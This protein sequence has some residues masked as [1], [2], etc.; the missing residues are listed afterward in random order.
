[1]NQA[2][3]LHGHAKYCWML[4]LRRL[5]TESKRQ[6]KLEG[7][8]VSV[9]ALPP[10]GPGVWQAQY[11]RLIAFPTVP[12]FGHS[13]NWWRDLTGVEPQSNIDRPQRQEQEVSGNY[14]GVE[15]SLAVVLLRAQW[16]A[17]PILDP[18]NPPDGFPRIGPFLERRMWFRDLM[19]RWLDQ[20]QQP[21][22]R[23]AFAGTLVQQVDDHR[24][25]YER[26]DQYLR[27]VDIDP[28]SSDFLYR[29]N[30]RRPSNSGIAG[31]NLNRLA[32]WAAMMFQIQR[33]AFVGGAPPVQQ[34]GRESHAATV[35][36]DINTSADREEPLPRE[37]LGQLFTE[38][39]DV[40]LD[41]ATHGDPR[42]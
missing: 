38:L 20:V 7:T 28:E 3:L 19:V 42:R 36:L 5:K 17:V 35:D 14:D 26:L 2:A 34:P 32:T 4:L 33:V 40:A 10:P 8:V 25:A 22:R 6:T 39:T 27:W 9:N 1:M 31:L 30:R 16:T 41:V 21:I 37:R 24:A 13:V 11:L 12:A 29:I 15:L 18:A 23:L